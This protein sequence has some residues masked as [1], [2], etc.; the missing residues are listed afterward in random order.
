MRRTVAW[1]ADNVNKIPSTSDLQ[2]AGFQA[3]GPETP[4]R[5]SKTC[6]LSLSLVARK[7]TSPGTARPDWAIAVEL[8]DRLGTDLGF[9][10]VDDVLAEIATESAIEALLGRFTMRTP[11]SIADE[12]EKRAVERG[13]VDDEDSEEAGHAPD[14]EERPDALT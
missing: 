5:N 1:T 10:S 4:R 2:T 12:D 9:G 14:T 13:D 11:G 8:A 7:V 3:A 6:T